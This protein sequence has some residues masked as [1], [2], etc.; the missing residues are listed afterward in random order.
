MKTWG[1]VDTSR[2]PGCCFCVQFNPSSTVQGWTFQL[3]R[4]DGLAGRSLDTRAAESSCRCGNDSD[5]RGSCSK[6]RQYLPR[7]FLMTAHTNERRPSRS[8]SKRA[9]LTPVSLLLS[10]LVPALHF[11]PSGTKIGGSSSA[12]GKQKQLY[13]TDGLFSFASASSSTHPNRDDQDRDMTGLTNCCGSL[14]VSQLDL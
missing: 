2:A 3:G 14:A 7:Q 4:G 13:S 11:S 10:C 9:G 5:R 8:Q 1:S 6:R 12:I